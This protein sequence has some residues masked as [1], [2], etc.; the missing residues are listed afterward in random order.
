[1]ALGACSM[2]C[3]REG[4]PRLA[5]RMRQWASATLRHSKEL[6]GMHEDVAHGESFPVL[7]HSRWR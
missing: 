2:P 7:R 5:T 3:G 1:M 4:N 6:R